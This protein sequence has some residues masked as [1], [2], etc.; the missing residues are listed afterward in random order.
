MVSMSSINLDLA[1]AAIV[2]MQLPVCEVFPILNPNY[3]AIDIFCRAYKQHR[4][5]ILKRHIVNDEKDFVDFRE[6]KTYTIGPFDENG[7][8]ITDIPFLQE[9][10]AEVP[11][12]VS[13]RRSLSTRQQSVCRIPTDPYGP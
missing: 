3:E 2:L 8:F 6:C 10:V 9:R 5:M 12:V 11:N 13:G 4:A 1:T 7:R